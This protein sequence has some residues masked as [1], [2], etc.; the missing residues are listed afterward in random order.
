MRILRKD[1]EEEIFTEDGFVVIK[2]TGKGL[3][4]MC[5]ETDFGSGNI[6]ITKAMGDLV[7]PE[8]E[9][10]EA[11]F[12]WSIN[13]NIPANTDI[14]ITLADSTD[15]NLKVRWQMGDA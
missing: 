11:G 15:P 8:L 3:L 6:V 2:Y 14:I 7:R 5:D 12:D 9:V 1:Y 10:Q 13:P 4:V